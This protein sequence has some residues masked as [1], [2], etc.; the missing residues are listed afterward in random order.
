[1]DGQKLK[2]IRQMMGRTQSEMAFKL[3]ITPQ[4]YSRM[5]RGKTG[6]DI[7]RLKKI[8]AGLDLTFEDLYKFNENNFIL[9]VNPKQGD[10]KGNGLKF[11]LNDYESEKSIEILLKMIDSQQKEIE[12]LR[13]QMDNLTKLLNKLQH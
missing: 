9:K 11:Q 12:F 6:I 5:E 8:A 3:N 1:M 7:E 4:A 10:E 2:K 13:T